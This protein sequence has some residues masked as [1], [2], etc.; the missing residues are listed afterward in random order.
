[1]TIQQQKNISVKDFNA[2]INESLQN[3]KDGKVI[4]ANALL[5]KIRQWD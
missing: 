1:M 5:E 2:Q 3:S 4:E